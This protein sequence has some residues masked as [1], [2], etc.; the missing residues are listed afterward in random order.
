M[1]SL[2]VQEI[3]GYCLAAAVAGKALYQAAGFSVHRYT[4]A[5]SFHVI[6]ARVRAIN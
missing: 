2:L 4:L 5:G 3:K 1:N 6:P